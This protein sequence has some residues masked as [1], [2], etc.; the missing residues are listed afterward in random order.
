VVERAREILAR[1]EAGEPAA[2]LAGEAS[3]EPRFGAPGPGPA[4]PS[5]EGDQLAIFGGAGGGTTAGA[6]PAAA[7]DPLREAL[8]GLDTDRLRPLEA[9]N[10]LAEWKRRYAD[11]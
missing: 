2:G 3:G 8:A 1:L 9:L 6:S 10:L 11:A 4:R 5:D 7:P